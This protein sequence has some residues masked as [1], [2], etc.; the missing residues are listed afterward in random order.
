V[1]QGPDFVT[2]GVSDSR[3]SGATE[4]A[5]ILMPP[6]R[7]AP[8]QNRNAYAT[9]CLGVFGGII[10][11]WGFALLSPGE[12][13]EAHLAG[14]ILALAFAGLILLG[15]YVLATAHKT[16]RAVEEHRVRDEAWLRAMERWDALFYCP[17][18]DQVYNPRSRRHVPSH[19]IAS[20]LADDS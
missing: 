11:L 14:G 7:P 13:A 9:G 6:D 8:L 1:F 19:G 2:V 17:R 12:G 20:L 5:Q 10:A 15:V 18:C 4:L 16:P 3:N